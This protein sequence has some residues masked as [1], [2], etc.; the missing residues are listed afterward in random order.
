MRAR[1]G[2]VERVRRTA[3]EAKRDVKAAV[4]EVKRVAKEEKCKVKA[5]A[6]DVKVGVKRAV[7]GR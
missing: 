2:T 4:G 6:K 1:E 3:K 7:T 5:S